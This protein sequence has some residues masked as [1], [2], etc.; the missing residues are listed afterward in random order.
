MQPGITARFGGQVVTA[1]GRPYYYHKET[2]KTSWKPTPAAMATARSPSAI[3]DDPMCSAHIHTGQVVLFLT[4]SNESFPMMHAHQRFVS[5]SR[6]MS[7]QVSMCVYRH[8]T[9]TTWKCPPAC[10]PTPPPP[11]HPHHHPPARSD[12]VP[13]VPYGLGFDMFRC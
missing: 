13:Y 11:P 6:P 2:R 8:H 12:A 9:N 4:L 5:M 7:I 1:E 10:P 3:A